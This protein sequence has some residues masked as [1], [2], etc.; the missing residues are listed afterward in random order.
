[1]QKV[2]CCKAD[3]FAF[4]CWKKRLNTIFSGNM[5]RGVTDRKDGMVTIADSNREVFAKANCCERP[6]IRNA[7][8]VRRV[9]T[10]GYL[11]RPSLAATR[12]VGSRPKE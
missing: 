4:E 2:L 7:H 10:L 12:L 9:Y 6:V 8:D 11:S 1:M 5:K 3:N